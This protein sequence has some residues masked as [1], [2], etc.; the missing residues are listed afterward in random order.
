MRADQPDITAIESTIKRIN[1][2]QE[3]VQKMAVH[4][5]LEMKTLLNREQQN[6]FLDLIAEAMKTGESHNTP[7]AGRLIPP[8][9][10]SSANCGGK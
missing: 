7:G 5:M 10:G 1:G 3:N 4:H 8:L 2:L 6:K 9:P